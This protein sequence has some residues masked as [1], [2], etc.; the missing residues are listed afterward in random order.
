MMMFVAKSVKDKTYPEY[1]KLKAFHK[2][3]VLASKMEEKVNTG[4]DMSDIA[5]MASKNPKGLMKLAVCQGCMYLKLEQCV[6]A[7][8]K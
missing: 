1:C 2:E 5:K 6:G 8:Y 4:F 3:I 7:S